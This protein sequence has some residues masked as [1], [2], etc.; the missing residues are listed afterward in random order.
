MKCTMQ[1]TRPQSCRALLIYGLAFYHRSK[2]LKCQF[3]MSHCHENVRNLYAN[4]TCHNYV[5]LHMTYFWH[6][7]DISGVNVT[8]LSSICA[9]QHNCTVQYVYLM[10]WLFLVRPFLIIYIELRTCSPVTW[11]FYTTFDVTFDTTFN[12]TFT[13]NAI[14]CHFLQLL[15]GW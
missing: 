4:L 14:M 11:T 15:H 7:P 13:V 2:F 10:A 12:M 9:S 3:D 6:M 5:I 1:A 8:L